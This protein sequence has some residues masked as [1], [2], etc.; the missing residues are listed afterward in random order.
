MSPF[1]YTDPQVLTVTALTGHDG[2][3]QDLF[4]PTLLEYGRIERR[5]RELRNN[6][7]QII[8][9]D[10]TLFLHPT[11]AIE[12]GHHVECQGKSYRVV[13]V[14]PCRL[15][16]GALDHFEAGLQEEN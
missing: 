3:G 16:D 4:G 12:T 10:A 5:R 1:G 8:V 2:A 13:L 11:S 6:L 7:D 15:L 14:E 9:I